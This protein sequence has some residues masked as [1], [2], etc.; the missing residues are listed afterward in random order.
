[1][2]NRKIPT[3]VHKLKGSYRKDRHGENGQPLILSDYPDAP[4]Y[5]IE[6]PGAIKVWDEVR[7]V[8][9]PAAIY[10]RADS[11]KLSRYCIL[12]AVFRDDPLTFSEMSTRLTQI[13]LLE[14]DLYLSPE[15]RAKITGKQKGTDNKF[16]DF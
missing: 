14:N 13:R 10:T 3:N 12:E 9:E 11:N 4:E 8:M 5:V 1:M 15:S 2:A 7:A 6:Y 16:S